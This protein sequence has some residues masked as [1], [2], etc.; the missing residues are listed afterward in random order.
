M[1]MVLMKVPVA[2]LNPATMEVLQLFRGDTIIVRRVL[3]IL[4]TSNT[5]LIRLQ[6]EKTER[7]CS[8]LLEFR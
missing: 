8:H 1:S 7:H 2:T 3:I 5:N 4:P 6:W